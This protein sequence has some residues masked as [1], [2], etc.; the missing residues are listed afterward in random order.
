MEPEP[1]WPRILDAFLDDSHAALVIRLQKGLSQG[2]RCLVVVKA[3]ICIEDDNGWS[4]APGQY[5]MMWRV[6]A[7]FGSLVASCDHGSVLAIMEEIMAASAR[8]GCY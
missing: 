8:L 4:Q 6:V 1:A 7:Y 5:I 3:N 2:Y